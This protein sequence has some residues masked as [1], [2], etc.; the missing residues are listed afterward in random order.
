MKNLFIIICIMALMF[1]GCVDFYAGKR[2]CDYPNSKWVSDN[3]DIYFM[4]FNVKSDF[5]EI[6]INEAIIEF[7]PRFD[8]GEKM[9]FVVIEDNGDETILFS[10]YCRFG[11]EKLVVTLSKD[12]T[13]FENNIKQLVFYREDML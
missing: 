3:P 8:Y 1:T 7:Y 13:F 2:P 9:D 10:G 12:Q 11:K 6:N 4:I 5:G